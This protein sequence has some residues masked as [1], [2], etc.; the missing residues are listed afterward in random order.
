MTCAATAI[1]FYAPIALGPA[2]TPAR[3]TSAPTSLALQP[4]WALTRGRQRRCC[5]RGRSITTIGISP[6]NDGFRLVGCATDRSSHHDRLHHHDQRHER[7]HAASEPGR[8]ARSAPGRPRVDSIPRTPTSPGWR[9]AD[10][11]VPAGQHLEDDQPVRPARRR[12]SP[13]GTGI[14]DVPVNGMAIDPAAAN[15]VYAATDIGVLS[16][17]PTAAST[18]S[19]SDRA[20]ARAA[21]F[22]HAYPETARRPACCIATHGRGIWEH[23]PLPVPVGLHGLRGQVGLVV[24]RIVKHGPRWPVPFHLEPARLTASSSPSWARMLTRRARY[25][26]PTSGMTGTEN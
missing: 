7:G 23:T 18:G 24:R 10:Y 13:P 26:T 15:S 19:Y 5:R 16:R 22:G 1:Q 8:R 9:S 20:L 17:R 12:G 4:T 25:E 11:S 14:P 21:V 3:S 2:A 6:A